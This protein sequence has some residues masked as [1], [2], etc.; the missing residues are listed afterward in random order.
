MTPASPIQSMKYPTAV[1]QLACPEKCA[2]QKRMSGAEGKAYDYLAAAK[3]RRERALG[4]PKAG[5]GAWS[6]GVW[7]IG[8]GSM[9]HQK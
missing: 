1:C 5:E 8:D 9:W 6:P 2:S 7:K 4:E 3:K